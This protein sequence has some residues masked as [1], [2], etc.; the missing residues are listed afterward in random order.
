MKKILLFAAVATMLAAC[1]DNTTEDTPTL[2]QKSTEKLYIAIGEENSRVQLDSNGQTVWNEGDMVSVFNKS[3]G[4]ERW[5]FDGKTGDTDGTLSKIDGTDG[6][7]IDRIIAVYPYDPECKYAYY[8]DPPYTTCIETIIPPVQNYADNSIC[9]GTHIMVATDENE[10]LQ[11]RNIVGWIKIS[12]TGTEKVDNITLKGNNNELLAGNVRINHL[13][14]KS[15][16]GSSSSYT[17]SR[18]LTIDCG[19]GVQLSDT[20]TDFYIAVLPQTF[21]KGIT[22]TIDDSSGARMTK[23]T[24]KPLTVE[25]NH[26]VPMS[27]LNTSTL[28]PAHNEI[29]YTSYDGQAVTPFASAEFGANIV[30]NTYE[31]G[32]GVIVFDGEVTVIGNS[33][34]GGG[35]LTSILL[36]ERVTAIGNRAFSSCSY[37]TNI[38][39]PHNLTSIGDFAFS[40][41]SSLSSI[42]IPNGVTTIGEYTFEQCSELSS[43][44]LPSELT[45]IGDCTF[46]NCIS[47]VSLSVPNSVTSIG[48][49]AFYQ[50]N[51]LTGINIPD[52]IT[53][54]A[55]NVFSGC[56]ALTVVEIPNGV[57]VIEDSAFYNC[58]GL[59]SIHIPEN[60]TIIESY[61][62]RGCTG[63][64]AINIPDGVISVK[65]AA[66]QDCS[67]L[68]SIRIPESVNYMGAKLFYGCSVLE[69]ANIPDGIT[70]IPDHL[71]CNC[72]NLKNIAIPESVT[73][74]LNDAFNG[75]TSLTEITI[76]EKITDIGGATF[77]DC[78]NLSAIFCKPINPP[79]SASGQST[80]G[81]LA[82]TAK[83]YVPTASVDAYKT[84]W[85]ECADMI[86]GYDF[87]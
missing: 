45:S 21:E 65:E 69:T 13:T 57:T 80:F 55:Q 34:F 59:T 76:P 87:Q 26:I 84:A 8:Y 32:S 7:P 22:L 3:T 14:L 73:R 30:S 66:F 60:V 72:H 74:I 23:C 20:P 9:G 47:L 15:S 5:R 6:D 81:N 44:R 27:A 50:C 1:T 36:P 46:Q 28:K 75:C 49:S 42:D 85:S 86:T 56:T 53:T 48:K 2:A 4:N 43:V 51:H 68:Q 40:G 33:A 41:C 10:I 17:W 64:T 61:V 62:F 79:L 71:F 12:L 37:L 38:G 67:S 39:I 52:G 16:I 78:S 58:S 25:R 31:N 77:R 19:E 29:Y 11:F 83:I 35:R 54:I 18:V 24:S 82:P 63:L 70:A